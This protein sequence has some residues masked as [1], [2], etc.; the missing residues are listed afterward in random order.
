[1]MTLFPL[2]FNHGKEDW[3]I[4]SLFRILLQGF[5]WVV[6]WSLPIIEG[7]LQLA[8][9]P[10]TGEQGKFGVRVGVGAGLVLADQWDNRLLGVTK[11]ILDAICLTLC[12]LL[13]PFSVYLFF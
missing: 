12:H 11:A 4:L 8:Q 3:I 1:M 10:F 5:T 2:T 13:I 7:Q 9:L 6:W